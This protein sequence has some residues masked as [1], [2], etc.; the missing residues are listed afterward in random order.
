L[1][2]NPPH[3]AKDAYGPVK[4]PEAPFYLGGEIHVPWSV[5]NIDL[6]IF[7]KAGGGGRGDGDPP[8]LLLLHP[9]HGGHSVVHFADFVGLTGVVE[10]PFSGGGFPASMCAMMPMLRRLSKVA[11]RSHPLMPARIRA[12]LA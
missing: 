1:G 5:D 12:K 10:D 8:V 9:V 4:D 7:P 11:S 3:S 2:L 6:K